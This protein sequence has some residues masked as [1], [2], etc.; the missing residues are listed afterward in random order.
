MY[1]ARRSEHENIVSKCNRQASMQIKLSLEVR[2]FLT[3]E[4][5]NNLDKERM[6]LNFDSFVFSWYYRQYCLVTG[7]Y[8]LEPW[9]RSLFNILL[10]SVCAFAVGD[11]PI[12]KQNKW[13]VDEKNSGRIKHFLRNYM[14]LNDSD[15]LLLFINQCFAPSPDQ[16]VRNLKDCFAPGDSKLVINYSKTQA[17]G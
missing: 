6:D 10:F 12:L 16:T 1:E 7:L 5:R 11:A 9:E 8:M 17:W 13:T 4:L 2:V 14:K 3:C 15:S